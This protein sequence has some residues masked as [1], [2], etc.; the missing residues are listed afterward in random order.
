MVQTAHERTVITRLRQVHD[1]LLNPT[2]GYLGYSDAN[3]FIIDLG[4]Y[5]ELTPEAYVDYLRRNIG[6][7][8]KKVDAVA[9]RYGAAA[10]LE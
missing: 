8:L 5:F 7:L 1:F 2:S 4:L 6:L 10:Y 3:K 9:A